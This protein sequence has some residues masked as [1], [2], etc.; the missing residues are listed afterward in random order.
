MIYLASAIG[1]VIVAI[2]VYGLSEKFSSRGK[3]MTWVYAFSRLPYWIIALPLYKMKV[4]G[5]ENVPAEGGAMIFA[6][7]SSYSDVILMGLALRRPIRFLSW[8]GF[9]SLPFLKQFMRA[10]GTIPIS[11]EH[12]KSGLQLAIDAVARGELICIFPEG[13]MTRNGSI[14]PFLGGFEL[15]AR[16]T[17]VPVIPVYIDGLWGSIFSHRGG[18]FFFKMPRI[19][20]TPVTFLFGKPFKMGKK[21]GEKRIFE[22]RQILL[23]LGSQAFAMRKSLDKHLASMLVGI[24]AR[25]PFKIGAI[26][27]SRERLVFRRGIIVAVS[28]LLAER[29]KKRIAARRVGIV[30]PA[31]TPGILANLAVS[32]AGKIPVNLNFTLGRTQVDACLAKAKIDT[33]ITVAPVRK[34][35][36]ERLPEFPWADKT[37]DLLDELKS[38]PKSK[39]VLALLQLILL[40]SFITKK[41]WKIPSQG[42]DN[43]AAILFT[44]GSSGTP[45]A[46]VITHKNLIANIEQTDD[47]DILPPKTRL[48]CNLPIFHSFGFMTLI[49]FA[50]TQDIVAITT[51]SPL[52]FAK[53]LKAIVADRP[54]VILSTPTFLRT[55]LKKATPEQMKSIYFTIAGAEKTPAGFADEW[56]KKFPGSY[57]LEGCGMTETSPIISVNKPDVP[58]NTGAP[59]E[60]HPG[61]K[62]GSVGILYPGMAAETR[63]VETGKICGFDEPGM[64]YLKGANVIP[65]YLGDDG[66]LVPATE[67]GWYKTGDIVSLDK[68]GF[69][70]IRGRLARFSKIGGEM[71]PHGAV[72]EEII[73]ILNI[74]IEDGL[75]IAV[76]ARPD[77][78]KGEQLVLLSTIPDLNLG[79]L[80]KRLS[81]NGFAN[82]WLPKEIKYVEKIPAL[83]TGK[84]D[85]RACAALAAQK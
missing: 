59:G 12:A 32:F 38:I 44:S 20:R 4:I 22:A 70:T 66:N 53:N 76:S 74:D 36:S 62:A 11:P 39:I 28:H 33:M 52:D 73:R 16:R 23:E 26:D 63:D 21:A 29:V 51:P 34:Q 68:F 43:E 56:E 17:G 25:H 54:T 13:G 64:L 46:A 50:M 18:K 3:Y 77:P 84:L 27:H 30:L 47:Y 61:R 75:K 85:I 60:V 65:G 49:W 67:N 8:E 35:I 19:S 71:V 9:E 6:N 45:K 24:C 79:E 41:L 2:V 40:P 55:Y 48:L 5:A 42:G 58:V 15:L 7:H 1:L 10:F 82:L 80:N 83:G 81:E 69:I 14:Q 37:I 57:Y 72:E 31:G 78:A